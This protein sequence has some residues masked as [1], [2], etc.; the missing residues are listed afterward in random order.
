METNMQHLEKVI[1][2]TIMLMVLIYTVQVNRNPSKNIETPISKQEIPAPAPEPT[3]KK[4]TGF[5]PESE[6]TLEDESIIEGTFTEVPWPE[7]NL[8]DVIAT[9]FS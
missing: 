1:M 8:P 3:P 6:P 9:L 2:F 4:E 7:I 5:F